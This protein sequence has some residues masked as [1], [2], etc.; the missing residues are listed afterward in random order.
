MYSSVIPMKQMKWCFCELERLQIQFDHPNPIRNELLFAIFS[1]FILFLTSRRSFKK[2]WWFSI[3]SKAVRRVRIN[4]CRL[5]RE[6]WRGHR[7]HFKLQS[8]QCW[9]LDRL[10]SKLIFGPKTLGRD[11]SARD[12]SIIHHNWRLFENI[13]WNSS[14]YMI[15][16]HFKL[17]KSNKERNENN[18]RRLS[19]DWF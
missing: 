8:R 4:P 2:M 10:S 3:W 6:L 11:L 9:V 18:L 5:H 15:Y 16:W 17:Q 19:K 1:K 12:N 13:L 14:Y 7:M